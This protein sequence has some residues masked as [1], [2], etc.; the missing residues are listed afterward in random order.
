M[1]SS[2]IDETDSVLVVIDVQPGFL[3]K[4]DE[5]NADEIV[6]RI[7]WLVRLAMLLGIPLLVT[8]EQPDHN[9]S[10]VERINDVVPA[11]VT[12]HTKPAFG[13]AACPPIMADLERHG[14]HTA[15][16]CGVETDVC[17]AQSAVG[18]V[19]AGWRVA[20]VEDAVGSPGA[21]H[22]Q[23]LARMRAAEVLLVG[24]KGLCYEWIRTVERVDGLEEFLSTDGP[25]GIVL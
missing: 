16:L 10:I 22:E 5:Q 17:V 25:L 4:L 15:V 2:L 19:D 18:L 13:L 11:A 23:G 6:D 8:Q 9:G 7:R 12:R 3:K 24:T 1:E 14:R 20:V 21:A